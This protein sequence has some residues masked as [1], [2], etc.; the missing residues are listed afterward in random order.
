MHTKNVTF[1]SF[2]NINIKKLKNV[3]IN[4]RIPQL[5]LSNCTT[6]ANCYA[7]QKYIAFYKAL[8]K[9]NFINLLHK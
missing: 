3:D 7:V 5:D 9:E 2:R 6:R 1:S 8:F 4:I